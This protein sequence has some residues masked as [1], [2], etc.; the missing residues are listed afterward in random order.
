MHREKSERPPR[1]RRSVQLWL[2]AAVMALA[3]LALINAY[4]RTMATFVQDLWGSDFSFYDNGR[5]VVVKLHRLPPPGAPPQAPQAGW[6]EKVLRAVCGYTLDLMG[7]SGPEGG[8]WR[9]AM[10]DKGRN[11][12]LLVRATATGAVVG[13]Y[14]VTEGSEDT[15]LVVV[16]LD[17]GPNGL[18]LIDAMEPRPGAGWF[19]VAVYRAPTSHHTTAPTSAP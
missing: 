13:R 17:A 5:T 11:R 16:E 10:E 3:M 18:H 1:P 6:P 14:R 7:L 4:G 19:V 9:A 8:L 12:V 15:G 2:T